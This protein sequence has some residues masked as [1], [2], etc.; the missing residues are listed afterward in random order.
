MAK[1]PKPLI[2]RIIGGLLMFSCVLM[3]FL[4]LFMEVKKDFTEKWYVPLIPL[5]VGCLLFFRLDLVIT[6]TS[7]I[8][9]KLTNAKIKGAEEA[10]EE[11]K[12]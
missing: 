9:D 5:G 8:A 3:Y 2:N 7:A 1:E 11:Q 10:K 12:P 4:P 6:T